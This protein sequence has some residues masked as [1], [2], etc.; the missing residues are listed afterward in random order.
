MKKLLIASSVALL[1]LSFQASAAP[2]PLLEITKQDSSVADLTKMSLVLPT[3]SAVQVSGYGQIAKNQSLVHDWGISTDTA[4]AKITGYTNI[5]SN[6]AWVSAVGLY[7]DASF[8]T[9]IASAVFK[10][11]QWVLRGVLGVADHIYGLRVEAHGDKTLTSG[12]YTTN[13]STVPVPA[14]AWLFGS[15]IAGLVGFGKRKKA[16]ALTA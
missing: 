8:T 13:V 9:K 4:G 6:K 10:D 5:A 11:N 16:A 15:A 12:S 3:R 2:K 1:A 14:A 7:S